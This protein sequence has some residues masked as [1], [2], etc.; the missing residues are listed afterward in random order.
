MPQFQ[1]YGVIF[2]RVTTNHRHLFAMVYLEPYQFCL[3]GFYNMIVSKQR[4][5]MIYHYEYSVKNITFLFSMMF[6]L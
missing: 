6:F 5:V 1:K 3:Q 4:P 2:Y